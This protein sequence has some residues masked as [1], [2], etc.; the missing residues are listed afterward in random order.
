MK[1]LWKYLRPHT[2]LI[3]LALSLAG[4]AQLLSLIDPIIFGKII[5]DYANNILNKPENEL[6]KGVLFWLFIAL[7]I[8]LLARLAR[9]LPGVCDATGSAEIRDAD[10]QRRT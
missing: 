3:I 1:I 6:V 8:A 4:V 7:G 10:I 5:D 9:K 2:G